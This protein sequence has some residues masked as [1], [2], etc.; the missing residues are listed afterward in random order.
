MKSGRCKNIALIMIIPLLF[1]CGKKQEEPSAAVEPGFSFK[2]QTAIGD[3][4]ISGT[5]G[6][7]SALIGDAV[8]L[9]DIIITG[10]NSIADLVYGASG[11]IRI[12]ANSRIVISSIADK[13]NNN[14]AIDM[15]NGKVLVTLSKLKGTGFNVKTQTVT[16][17]VRGTSFI[18][19]SGEKG[20]RLLVV[21]GTV[22]LNPVKDG[23][24]I[25]DKTITVEKG[26]KT[27]FISE[28]TVNNIIA[29]KTEMPVIEITDKEI[30]EIK[31]EVK[32]MKIESIQGL[33]S[34]VIDEVNQ[35]ILEEAPAAENKDE[36]IREADARKKAV[37]AEL[38]K[39]KVEAEAALK[40]EEER[41]RL[42]E[43]QKIKEEQ[44]LKEEKLK[45]EEKI[46][47]DRASNIP[48]M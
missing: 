24:V 42:E 27:D 46:K 34:A 25:E 11:V 31:A 48:T 44:R 18:V 36:G 40:Q 19:E 17:G 23:R 33:D 32:E 38:L 22:A 47:K 35:N 5:G 39:K 6:E 3:V 16:A 26:M 29:G 45:K 8:V 1:S 20:G 4:K 43:E 37:E 2:I 9:N 28:K 30:V 12:S 41:K 13:T 10:K 21:K 14:T 15:K 7:R